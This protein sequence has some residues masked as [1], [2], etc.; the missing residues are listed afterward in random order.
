MFCLNYQ[1]LCK[2]ELQHF[3][4]CLAGPCSQSAPAIDCLDHDGISLILNRCHYL[5][6]FYFFPEHHPFPCYFLFLAGNLDLGTTAI[7]PIDIQLQEKYAYICEKR[8]SWSELQ[9]E[10]VSS[11]MENVRLSSNETS[12]GSSLGLPHIVE[13]SG[14][15]PGSKPNL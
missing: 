7:L 2:L 13:L 8:N 12:D 5:A 14:L 11:K 1:L 3:L 4:F 15:S 9:A 10:Q 6:S